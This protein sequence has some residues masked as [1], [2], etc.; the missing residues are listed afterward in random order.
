MNNNINYTTARYGFNNYFGGYNRNFVSNTAIENTNNLSKIYTVTSLALLVFYAVVFSLQMIM[1]IISSVMNPQVVNQG[2]FN[3]W[4]TDVPLYGVAL[5]VFFFFMS[6]LEAKKPEKKKFGF[7]NSAS[8][9]CVSCFFMLAGSI[10]GNM[11]DTVMQGVFQVE[12]EDS[13]SAVAST[14]NLPIQL[15]FFVVIAPIGEELIFRKLILDRIARFGE[16]TAIMYTAI[17]F[18][19]FHG[20]FGQLFYAFGMGLLLG[21]LYVKTG[22]YIRCVLLH[23]AVNCAFGVVFPSIFN[24]FGA[25]S[26]EAGLVATAELLLVILGIVAFIL[27]LALKKVK[28]EKSVYPTWKKASSI[29]FANA[30][31]IVY[32]IIFGISILYL[33]Y[34]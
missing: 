10:I 19:L 1:I 23:G 27:Y 32:A 6:K 33:N 11:A 9:F 5:W 25:E 18:A 2:W 12:Q 21:Y 15:I 22:S 20:N 31:F 17:T 26:L 13:L 30:P 8:I 4:A 34:Q 3:L 16:G 7:L 28:V 24:Y 14:M 29:A